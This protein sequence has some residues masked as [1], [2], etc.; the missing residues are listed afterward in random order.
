MYGGEDNVF[1]KD[2]LN[3]SK[4]TNWTVSGVVWFGLMKLDWLK[5]QDEIDA[6][7]YHSN[8]FLSDQTLSE[9]DDCGTEYDSHGDSAN[10]G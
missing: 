8:Q 6:Q 4:G 9:P 10:S 3:C 1:L 5:V 2:I 7:D